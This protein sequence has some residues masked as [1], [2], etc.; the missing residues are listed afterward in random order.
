MAITE[1]YTGT[2]TV[3]TTELSL[4]SGTSVLQS[5]TDDGVY[6]VFLDLNAVANGDVFELRIKEKVTSAGTQRTIATFTLSDA[7]GADNAVWASPSLI[8]M[9]GWD[10]TMDKTVGTDRSIPYSIRRVA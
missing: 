6:Q 9:H 1:V 7:F 4:V 8:L 3:S 5:V 2:L 10:V